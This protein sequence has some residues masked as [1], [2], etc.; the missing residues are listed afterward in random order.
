MTAGGFLF[1]SCVILL[2]IPGF[3][4]SSPVLPDHEYMGSPA[5]S[6]RIE[7]DEERRALDKEAPKPHGHGRRKSLAFHIPENLE[8]NL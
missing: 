2:F 7:L 4:G 1:V 6:S 5:S 3:F 8:I